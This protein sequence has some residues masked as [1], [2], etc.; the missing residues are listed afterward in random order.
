LL[1]KMRI[2]NMQHTTQ[3]IRHR[4]CVLHEARR[5]SAL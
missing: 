2:G 3:R 5:C 1:W 4:P